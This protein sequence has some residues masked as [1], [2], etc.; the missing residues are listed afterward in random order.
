MGGFAFPYLFSFLIKDLKYKNMINE[1][2]AGLEKILAAIECGRV[3]FQFPSLVDSRYTV[4]T[5]AEKD[6][7]ERKEQTFLA[8]LLFVRMIKVRRL[9]QH[10]Q[11][12]TEIFSIEFLD[13]MLRNFKP[14]DMMSSSYYNAVLQ[15]LFFAVLSNPKGSLHPRMFAKEKGRRGAKTSFR[16]PEMF[17]MSEEEVVAFFDCIDVAIDPVFECLDTEVSQTGKRCHRDGFSREPRASQRA[18]IS[19]TLFFYE[20]EE[21][22]G[23]IPLLRNLNLSDDAYEELID[24]VQKLSSHTYYL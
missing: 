22:I 5:V 3:V 7:V 1:T 8:R 14:F 15:N 18:R 23:L 11:V 19:N 12:P 10:G 4:P 2:I 16:Y 6:Y 20:G 17:A 13:K 21:G 24:R 9:M